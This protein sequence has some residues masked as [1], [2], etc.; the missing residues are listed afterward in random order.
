MTNPFDL[1]DDHVLV[2]AVKFLGVGVFAAASHYGIYVGLV[3]LAGVS[4]TLSTLAGFVVSTGISYVLNV[5]FT[6]K[7][8]MSRQ[9]LIRFWTVTILG[10]L[11]NATVV[12]VG[13]RLI[14]Y[15]LAGVIA[16]VF[17]ASFNFT[18]HKLWTFPSTSADPDGTD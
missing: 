8:D 5:R 15:R 6:F 10:G 9:T 12:E 7:A 14:D 11:I 18:G 2:Q 16:I 4:P 13:A 17:G 3:A 1:P